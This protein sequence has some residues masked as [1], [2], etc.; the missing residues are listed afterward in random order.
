MACPWA[1]VSWTTTTS[2]IQ[3][4][5][6]RTSRRSS[7]IQAASSAGRSPSRTWFA[8][9]TGENRI[10]AAGMA[11]PRLTRP[12]A[13]VAPFL[14]YLS[15]TAFLQPFDG[16]FGHYS[17]QALSEVRGRMVW[18][19]C[20]FRAKDEGH[21]FLLPGARVSGY[22][23]RAALTPAELAKRY[24]LFAV[25]LPLA[26][27]PACEGCTLIGSR[28]EI[29]GRQNGEEIKDMLNS[30]GL[31]LGQALEEK[32]ELPLEIGE[33]EEIILDMS[34][35]PEIYDKI[36]RSIAPSIYGY[37]DVKEALALQLASGFSK[38]LPDSVANC[39]TRLKNLIRRADM[40]SDEW[41]E[42]SHGR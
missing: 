19:P 22:Y 9:L 8:G 25:Q 17:P 7:R 32:T 16:A 4:C 40:M 15:F 33:D 35:D 13:L 41:D 6:R 24:R 42:P 31:R 36:R 30:K 21:R 27:Q 34:R 3:G 2:P 39:S 37:E 28:L 12:F 20:D 18:T 14:V 26:E 23:E 10:V 5:W 38:R 29:R 1:P 11:L